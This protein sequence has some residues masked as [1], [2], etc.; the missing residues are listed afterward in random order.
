MAIPKDPVIL[1]SYLNTLLRDKYHDLDALC[2]GEDV[3]RKEI[4]ERITSIGYAYQ[5]ETNQIRP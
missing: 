1:V 4:E 2:D 5:S 3:S